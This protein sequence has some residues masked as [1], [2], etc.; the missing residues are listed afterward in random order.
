[1]KKNY[2]SLRL[3]WLLL[4]VLFAGGLLAQRPMEKLG[5]GLMVQKISNGI[6]VNWRINADEW[7]NTY[8]K[9]YRDGNLIYTTKTT[10]ASN[11]LDPSG[12]VS[13]KYSVSRVKNGVESTPSAQ[14]T[15]NTK[16]YIDI[17]MH[18]VKHGYTLNDAT[19]ADL[20]GD[21]EYEIIVKRLNLDFSVA[22]DSAYSYFEAYKLDG[23]FLWEI[24]V[25]PNILSSSGVE[26]NIAAYDF[27][28][29][30]KAEVFMRTSEGTI[31]GDGTK[32]GD[33]N[34]DGTD[35]YRY[36][37]VQSPNMQY[38]N[39][40]PEFLSLID[41][42]TGKE[43]DR[44]NFIP[45]GSSSDW[46]DSYGHRANKFFFGAPYF[47]GKHPSLFIARGIYTKT[48]MRAYDIV[49]KKIVPRTSWGTNGA[50]SSGSS[51]IY[52]GQGYHN[53]VVADTDGD[54]CDEINYGSMCIDH[55]GT[56]LYS[57][58]LGH[59]D[60]Q[61]VGDFDPYRKGI[62]VFACNEDNPGINYRDG[63][64]G[65][66][67]YRKVAA[68]DVGRAGAG[69]ISDSFKG[70][71]LWGNGVGIS[72]TDRV[73]LQHFGV[74]ENYC[75]YWDG[76]L[77]QEILDH[78]GF[79]TATG[80]GYG[81]ISKFNG[82]GN[83]SSLLVADAYS[84]NYT[85]GTPCLQADLFGDWREEAIWW[86][87]DSMALRIYTTPIPTTN[88]IYSLMADHQYR[89]AICWQM[90]GYNQPPHTSFYLG[91]DFPTPIPPKATN[92]K[93]VWNGASSNWDTSSANWYDGDDAAGLIA[94]NSS[95]MAYADAKSV[96][97]DTHATNTTVTIPS[98][99]SPEGLTVSGSS[100]YTIGGAGALT[101]AMYLAKMGEGSLT[102]NGNHSYTGNTEIWEGDLWMNGALSAS[103]V[104]IRR[105]ANYGGTGT[106]GNGISTEYNAGI[107][108]GGKAVAD[109][110]TVNG[111]INLV[112][113]AKLNFD[114]S[115]NPTILT[116]TATGSS[117]LKNDY[118]KLNGTLQLGTGA[119]VA[120]NPISGKLTE[121]KYLIAKVN[122]ISG[123]LSTVKIE[124]AN[125]VATELNYDA[126]T[127][128]LY[129]IVKGVRGAG[130]VNWTG[131]S[132][133]NWNLAKTTNFS[134]DGYDDIFVTNDS[135]YFDETALKRIVNVVDSV[136]PA[137]VE[138]NSSLDYSVS[139]TGALIGPMEL[140]KTN[141]G[142]L[143]INNR[144]TFTG[145]VTVDQGSL[146]LKY[147][148]SPTNFGSIG[149][150]TANPA[151]F[152][153]KDSANLQ[154]TTANETT[155][156][157]LTLSGTAG[158]LMN[159]TGA[160]YWNGAIQGTKLTKYGSSILYIGYNNTT[161]NETVVKEGTLRL[162][163]STSV[164]YGV[165]KKVT[166]MGGTLETLNEI[167]TYLTSSHDF[168]IPASNTGTVIAGPRCEY[169]GALTGAGTLNWYCDYIRCYLNGNWSAYTGTINVLAN[170]ANSSYENHFI[171]NNT[172]GFP[173]ATVN[174]GTGVLMVYKN[175][176]AD[177]GTTT[178]KA[179]MLTGSGNI[180]NAGLQVGSSNA[181]GTFS[182]VISGATTVT[183][184]GTG[185]WILSGAN[186]YTGTTTI[187]G[188]ILSLT[189][190]LGTGVVSVTS[191][192]KL[193]NS[194]TVA[195]AA[196]IGTDGI[197]INN[198]TF[199]STLT[200]NGT[201]NGTG[202]ISGAA[203][204]GSNSVTNPGSTAIGTMTFGSNVTMTSTATLNMQMAGGTSTSCDNMKVAGTFTCN[205]TLNVSFTSGTPIAGAA[206]QLIS[207]TT[208]SGTFATLNLPTLPE[209]LIWDTS[210]LY[211]TGK[212]RISQGMGVETTVIKTG[213]VQNPTSGIFRV[214]TDQS[215]S[216]MSAI[217]ANLQGRIVYQSN[218][219]EITG[220]T[221]EIDLTSQPTGVYLLKVVSEKASSKAIK[222]I[223]E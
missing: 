176:T 149:A 197:V 112:T 16:G 165:G 142:S 67:L 116:G 92:G 32:I 207:A 118:L 181:S 122:A 30:G 86:R 101:G 214:Y 108:I 188:G 104:T 22:N 160:L 216:N 219:N 209:G 2:F 201:L 141:S 132:D 50:W 19:A 70:A 89:Q 127:Q 148:P 135:V 134:K 156:R 196:I 9:V 44:V 195:G 96:L 111:N 163:T 29:D 136:K 117:A 14:V 61:H 4:S 6:Y 76:D 167:G 28:G 203:T 119:I 143:T 177:N 109:T 215:A 43:L 99:I 198:S 91:S 34:G 168:Y 178:I 137:Y 129:L 47:D 123:T 130:V 103:P 63:K 139:G 191:G 7:Y 97:F 106:T 62:E 171:V 175:G 12:T 184:V 126:T 27:D 144:N 40:G 65:Q 53:Y 18:A 202:T 37:V 75:V 193:I 105:H 5:R 190:S 154:I 83:I 211:T 138:F 133:T 140:Y 36:S 159:V 164:P 217:V 120:L 200:N 17:P 102:L 73:D 183:K 157:G 98:N 31:F 212:L 57:T 1:M 69:N 162:N 81:A 166:L 204:L 39:A 205:G 72:A 15:V 185:L 147:A 56:G 79:S 146:I 95:A 3:C 64:T 220:G 107:Y 48:E 68:S 128:S 180:Y 8:Y 45:R 223:K 170:G 114:I 25:G 54:G 210:E 187:S 179:G 77:L 151:Y 213:V 71:E 58:G 173:N 125:G 222:L 35:N 21:G 46:G 52:Y 42:A 189:G 110:M 124:G 218:V 78:T 150:N 221:F 38:M 82:Y 182:G 23:T 161:L 90:C 208:I 153:L 131:K 158:G 80:V 115:D 186:T 49:N 169:N 113:G 100:N 84:C 26:I 88:R 94:G 20:D 85:K 121:G 155:T 145:K 10:E 172:N 51:G 152:I 206:Y 194:G 87:T 24:N 199:A 74:A 33:T 41:G 59:G 11:Y 192:G 93:L 66:I 60:A 13:S 174:I 55:N